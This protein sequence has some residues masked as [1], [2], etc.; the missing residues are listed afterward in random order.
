MVFF[1]RRLHFLFLDGLDFFGFYTD[2]MAAQ[3]V[4]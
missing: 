3:R 1:L 4:S 2:V